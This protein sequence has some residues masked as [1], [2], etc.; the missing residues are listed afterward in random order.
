M[1]S[2]FIGPNRRDVATPCFEKAVVFQSQGKYDQALVM[3]QQSLDI[4]IKD[5]GPDNSIVAS[6]YN[7]MAS[8][9]NELG[10][11]ED[12]LAFLVFTMLMYT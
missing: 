9:Y 2:L 10:K 1:E 3:Y 4:W 6:T 5:H 8:V 7:N 11:F 12:A